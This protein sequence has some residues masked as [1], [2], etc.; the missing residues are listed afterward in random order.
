MLAVFLLIF[1]ISFF[2]VAQDTHG[3]HSEATE[4]GHEATENKINVKEII[5]GHIRDSHDW[6]LFSIGHFHASLPLPVIL[7][8]PSHGLSVF[9]SSKFEHGHAEYN[10]Y[11]QI[12]DHDIEADAAM[13]NGKSDLAKGK[14][15]SLDGSK[16]YNFSITKNVLSMFISL[17]I[18]WFLL[19]GIAK[20]YKRN[21]SNKAPSGWQN[22]LEPVIGFIDENV[23]EI[24]NEI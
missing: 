9:M 12:N 2:A 15:I 11:K 21:G 16:F 3:G 5:F 13:H 24:I 23:A 18:L 8:N 17:A 22:A 19:T 6:H 1:G 4:A 20:K 14:I 10:G 7:Y